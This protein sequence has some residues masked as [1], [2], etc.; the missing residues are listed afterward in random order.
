MACP[1]F[2][3]SPDMMNVYN[4]NVA[5]DGDGNAVVELPSYFEV[6]NRE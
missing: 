6:L 1:C 3:A 2:V 5:T 4:G